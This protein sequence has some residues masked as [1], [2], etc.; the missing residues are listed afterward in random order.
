MEEKKTWDL[1]SAASIPLV[2]TLGN[3]ML[4][5][6]LPIMEKKLAISPLQ[7]SMVITIYSIVAII[8]IP[9]AGFLSD[10]LGRKAIIVP[11]LII[12]GL[13]GLLSSWAAF[14]MAHPY[15]MILIGRLLQGAGAAGAFPIV[16]PLVGDMFQR[17][18]DISSGLGMIETSNTLGKVL[19]P[20]LGAFLAAF[21]W[22]LPFVSIPFFCLISVLLVAFFVKTPKTKEEPKKFSA[23]KAS[24]LRI[25]KN[26][27]RWLYAIFL[28]GCIAMFVLFGVLFHLSSLLED[29]YHI[30]G[31]WKGLIL[32]IP[33]AALCITS[34]LGGRIIG[35][36]K[37]LMKWLSFSGMLLLAGSILWISYT[38]TLYFLIFLVC[39]NGIGIGAA[40]PSLDALITQE[41]EKEERGTITSIYSSARF[42]GVALGPPVFAILIKYSHQVLFFTITGVCLVAVLLSLFAIRPP[43]KSPGEKVSAPSLIKKRERAK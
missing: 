3:S 31:I 1:I 29:T 10:R 19:S 4:I 20:I 32:A 13:G 6:V 33:L 7:A 28:I 21:V 37:L 11:S 8:L 27:G 25:F 43:D 34:Y 30:D 18:S 16:I 39:L 5:P 35:E 42:I 14:K 9:F 23:F 2:M 36:N 24:I 26:Q 38:S 12:A 15:V 22:H 40:L 41:F 17:K